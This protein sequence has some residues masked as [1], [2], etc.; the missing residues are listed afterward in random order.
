M[1]RRLFQ[2]CGDVERGGL[3][4]YSLNVPSRKVEHRKQKTHPTLTKIQ[5]TKRSGDL[6]RGGLG[7]SRAVEP[8][9]EELI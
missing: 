5:K 8:K 1:E 3:I 4:I 7:P 6:E 2:I 9:K